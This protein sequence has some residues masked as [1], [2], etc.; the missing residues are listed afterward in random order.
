[1]TASVTKS[2]GWES[3]AVRN[4]HEWATIHIRSFQSTG[5][6][7]NE[8]EVGEIMIHSSYGSWAYQWGHLGRPFKE[9]IAKTTD[10][11]Y[12]AS[13]FLGDK[14]YVFDG[15]KTVVGLRESLI[16]HR[17][18][19]SITKASAREVWDW[20]DDNEGQLESSERDFVDT[21]YSGQTQIVMTKGLEY[22]F[23]EPWE[24]LQTVLD[25]QFQ[26][27][28]REIMPAFQQALRDELQPVTT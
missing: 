10:R 16:E 25:W 9:W 6:D 27:F 23:S 3:Y 15:Q 18:D 14:A 12:I 13:K 24:R 8:R 17:R 28:W 5:I 26:G 22:F 11:S 1:M 19:G 4:N 21:M 20:I 2:T 7:S